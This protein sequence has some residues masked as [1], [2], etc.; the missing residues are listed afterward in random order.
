MVLSQ[1]DEPGAVRHAK[2]VSEGQ[3]MMTRAD[4]EEWK[5]C[6]EDGELTKSRS[7]DFCDNAKAKPMWRQ[8]RVK[9]GAACI[10]CR[11]WRELF[12][13]GCVSRAHRRR[14]TSKFLVARKR[15]DE[16][17]AKIADSADPACKREQP[18]ITV[19]RAEYQFGVMC[20]E[21]V[22]HMCTLQQNRSGVEPD[23]CCLCQQE[24]TPSRSL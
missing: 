2:I 18:A 15:R 9:R 8:R 14:E 10:C 6:A 21:H 7:L 17:E 20:A 16:V 3:L 19:E 4:E 5:D 12:H 13:L 24:A 23:H 1:Q 11:V 22:A